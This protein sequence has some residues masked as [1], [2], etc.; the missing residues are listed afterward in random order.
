MATPKD[1][2]TRLIVPSSEG[3]QSGPL[4]NRSASPRPPG[5]TTQKKKTSKAPAA[6]AAAKP[7]AK[8][9]VSFISETQHNPYQPHQTNM[10]F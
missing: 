8:G 9:K 1:S 6:A 3:D 4:A 7:N 5:L 10:F 2:R